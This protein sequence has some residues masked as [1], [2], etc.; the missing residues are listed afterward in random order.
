MSAQEKNVKKIL[1]RS[2]ASIVI[3]FVAAWSFSLLYEGNK[4]RLLDKFDK[5]AEE[6][7]SLK[8]F[9]KLHFQAKLD[10][11]ACHEGGVKENQPI[12]KSK[13]GDCFICH[14]KMKEKVK[15]PDNTDCKACHTKPVTW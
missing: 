7:S 5:Q 8:P 1:I 15:V 3:V 11:S 10:C 4:L 6:N 9:H 2:L 12:A 14:E 13:E